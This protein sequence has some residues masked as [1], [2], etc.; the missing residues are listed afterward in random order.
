MNHAA[1]SSIRTSAWARSENLFCLEVQRPG[2]TCIGR[3][4]SRVIL[5]A[6]LRPVMNCD[7]NQL[8]PRLRGQ[9]SGSSRTDF[10]AEPGGSSSTRSVALIGIIRG[11]WSLIEFSLQGRKTI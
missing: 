10:K 3:S 8:V 1:H 5:S 9:P 7:H 6:A 11:R 4:S 2:Q